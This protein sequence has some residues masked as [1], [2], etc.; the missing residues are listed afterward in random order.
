MS[1]FKLLL[2]VFNLPE[3]PNIAPATMSVRPDVFTS[4]Y[5]LGLVVFRGFSLGKAEHSEYCRHDA[6]WV[7]PGASPALWPCWLPSWRSSRERA[8]VATWEGSLCRTGMLNSTEHVKVCKR[9]LKISKMLWIEACCYS[10]AMP[11]D[12]LVNFV[13][14][15]LTGA[16]FSTKK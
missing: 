2:G 5:L 13:F 7:C 16:P 14:K 1:L 3:I 15:L 10:C 9:L 11:L 8:L 4:C 12:V 6:V